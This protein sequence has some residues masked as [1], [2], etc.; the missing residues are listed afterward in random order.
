MVELTRLD[1]KP[2]CSAKIQGR[3]IYF[4]LFL[5]SRKAIN[6]ITK[7]PKVI[8]K[9]NI[10]IKIEMISKAVIC[11]TSLLMYSDESGMKF[12]EVYHLATR[13]FLYDILPYSLFCDNSLSNFIYTTLCDVQTVKISIVY[14]TNK[15]CTIMCNVY[16]YMRI[17]TSEERDLQ[18]FTRQES[19]L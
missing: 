18:K 12:W 10:P 4:R 17:S 13:L 6:A 16:S 15:G 19:T 1:D 11:A 8:S 9:A 3:L 7:L 14:L 2:T 5:L